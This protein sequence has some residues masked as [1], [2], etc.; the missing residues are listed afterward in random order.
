MNTP[1]SPNPRAKYSFLSVRPATARVLTA[2]AL[3]CLHGWFLLKF[4][5][6]EPNPILIQAVGLTG[7]VGML[8]AVFVF[9]TRYTFQATANRRELDERELSQRNEAYYRTYQ[10]VI[11]MVLLGLVVMEFWERSTGL[12]ISIGQL[13]NFFTVLFFSVLIMPATVLAWQDRSEPGSD[14]D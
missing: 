8:A 1:Q 11:V 3:A 4:L 6:V 12:E 14:E 10:Y 7:L 2:L 13:R 9:L 5:L